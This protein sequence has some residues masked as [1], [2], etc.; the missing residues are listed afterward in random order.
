MKADEADNFT[1]T[2]DGKAYYVAVF[3]AANNSIIMPVDPLLETLH[4]LQKNGM[5]YLFKSKERR[6]EAVQKMTKL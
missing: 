1:V 5:A 4:G 3:R 6:D 2:V